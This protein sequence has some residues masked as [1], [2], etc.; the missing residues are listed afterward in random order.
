M[1][2]LIGGGLAEEFWALRKLTLGGAETKADFAIPGKRFQETNKDNCAFHALANKST[3]VGQSLLILPK[4]RE[5][6]LQSLE[7]FML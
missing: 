5:D 3:F 6:S 1:G 4:M 7:S 2:T